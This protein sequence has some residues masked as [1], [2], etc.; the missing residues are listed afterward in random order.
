MATMMRKEDQDDT[1]GETA[2]TETE[3]TSGVETARGRETGEETASVTALTSEMMIAEI[4]TGTEIEIETESFRGREIG[5]KR[6]P[7]TL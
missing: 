7:T 3:S 2:T 1:T 4:E 5:G 6:Y